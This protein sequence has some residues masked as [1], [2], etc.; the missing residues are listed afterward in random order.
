MADDLIMERLAVV[1]SIYAYA[2]QL[3]LRALA[4]WRQEG[5]YQQVRPSAVRRAHKQQQPQSAEQPQELRCPT[6][7]LH[8]PEAAL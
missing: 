1:R 4:A 6:A 3:K 8:P 2:R 7:L 5:A